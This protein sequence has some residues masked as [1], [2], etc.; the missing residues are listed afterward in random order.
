MSVHFVNNLLSCQVIS[1]VRCAASAVSICMRC[2]SRS[3]SDRNNIH[4]FC[5]IN[6]R[7]RFANV[8]VLG[9]SFLW[10]LLCIIVQLPAGNIGILSR[11]FISYFCHFYSFNLFR[12]H[13]CEMHKLKFKNIIGF[14]SFENRL[15]F[16]LRSSLAA[17]M[18]RVSNKYPFQDQM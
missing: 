6:S 15:V 14:Y 5:H 1:L 17:H 9:R 2:A 13:K 3:Q 8:F 4:G 12:I 11:S 18:R 10:L 7:E 16:F